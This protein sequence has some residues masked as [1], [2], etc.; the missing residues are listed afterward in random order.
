MQGVMLNGA[1]D[2]VRGSTTPLEEQTHIL[3]HSRSSGLI[4]QVITELQI[5]EHN[6]PH[7]S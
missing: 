4:V 6:I 7:H 5:H 3:H 2:A 1:A